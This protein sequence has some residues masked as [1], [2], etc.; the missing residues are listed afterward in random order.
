M[1]RVPTLDELRV[2]ASNL[3]VGNVR[4]I[5]A[6]RKTLLAPLNRVQPIT[7]ALPIAGQQLARS[8]AG[9]E[10]LGG[11][12]L[13]MATD[14]KQEDLQQQAKL[15]Y[16]QAQ[17][18]AEAQ[19]QQQQLKKE[20]DTVQV[21]R[22][23]NDLVRH[24]IHL[25]LDPTDGYL[26]RKG[27]TAVA[28]ND[29]GESLVDEYSRRFDDHANEL[30][31][32]LQ[33]DDQRRDFA[34]IRNHLK[35]GFQ[36]DAARH[37]FGETHAVAK[38]TAIG[39]IQNG[40]DLIANAGTDPAKLTAGIQQI[41]YSSEQ[42]GRYNGLH[43]DV[44]SQNTHNNISKAFTAAIQNAINNNQG[45]D[46]SALMEMAKS[47]GHL[48][49]AD[50]ADI[51]PAVD[52]YNS[53]NQVRNAADAVVKKFLPQLNPTNF[54]RLAE[55]MGA[56][57]PDAQQRVGELYK[58]Q[59]GDY[60]RTWIAWHEG[61]DK[62]KQYEDNAKATNQPLLASLPQDKINQINADQSLYEAKTNVIGNL[63]SNEDINTATR[64]A[65][66]A[67]GWDENDLQ[68][69]ERTRAHVAN[70]MTQHYQDIKQHRAVLLDQKLGE[71]EKAA[72]DLTQVNLSGL[73]AEDRSRAN[74]YAQKI[75]KTPAI[76]TDLKELGKWNEIPDADKLKMSQEEVRVKLTGKFSVADIKKAMNEVA[77]L[78]GKPVSD[79]DQSLHSRDQRV[80]QFM[81]DSGLVPLKGADEKQTA[82]LYRFQEEMQKRVN[83]YKTANGKMPDY[84]AFEQM[85]NYA[86]T[87][88]AYTER[89]NGWLPDQKT[90]AF[91]VPP[92]DQ[93][94]A[95]IKAGNQRIPVSD[96]KKIKAY[97][98]RIG[99]PDSEANVLQL[100][101]SQSGIQ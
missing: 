69:F 18:Q 15:Q 90:K 20:L 91:N 29:Q 24:G 2:G 16:E 45:G 86:F 81:A 48:T 59:G 73:S 23:K 40:I 95:Y 49:D 50:L 35:S 53:R 66:K 63:P 32:Q 96:F 34:V 5:D 30:E 51:R 22:V 39:G 31:K 83:D 7:E 46:A 80:R 43:P 17:Q 9:M 11:A 37:L 77:T 14:L 75:S 60:T 89:L 62:L 58:A 57:T 94:K 61:P 26:A 8:G 79:D 19:R 74:D 41:T 98:R 52:A 4:G 33:N 13:D 10:K 27:Y 72:G 97:L 54:D 68:T 3:A 47:Q 78:Q 71:I 65:L 76:K 12:V 100:W 88:D 70:Q 6:P 85:M 1:P 93:D 84:K 99:K 44:I 28:K 56:T 92:Q 21:D 64:A 67:S 55:N 25:Q 42:A 101:H 82:T 38:D 87:Q 36:E